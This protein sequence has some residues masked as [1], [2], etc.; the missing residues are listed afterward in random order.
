ML[1]RWQDKAA[2][3]WLKQQL[4]TNPHNPQWHYLMGQAQFNL[5]NYKESLAIFDD[6]IKT[7][8]YP[9]FQDYRDFIANTIQSV[10]QLQK[11]TTE[12]FEIFIDP[13]QDAALMPYVAETL[14][15]SY[16]RLGTLFDWFPPNR[17]RV[18]IFPTQDTF[19]PASSLSARDIEVSGAI[20]ICKFD[21][22]MLLSPRNLSRGYRWTDALSHEYIHYLLIHLSANRAPIWLHEG[23]AKYFEDA[24]RLPQS[25]WLSL[26]TET[27][28]A[29]ALENNSF[30]GF[31]NMEPSLVKLESTYQVQL[32]YA[33]AAS[34][35][36]FIVD[37]LGTTG[38]VRILRELQQTEDEG[39]TNTIARLMGYDATQFEQ[40]WRQFLTDKH[41]QAHD[42]MQLSRFTLKHTN[43]IPIHNLKQE[44]ESKTARIHVRLGDRLWQ[45]GRPRAAAGEYRRA[46]RKDPYSPYLLNKLAR[47]LMTQG[48]WQSAQH[49]LEQAKTLDPDYVVTHTNLGRLFISQ[50]A[51][52]QARQ[53]LEEAVQINPFDPNIH[54]YLANSYRRLGLADKAEQENNLFKRLQESP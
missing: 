38:L 16:Q 19:Y 3:T 31:K 49:Y 4:K 13:K 43:K 41:L 24:W 40:K 34:A 20:G 50:Q 46:L 21:K 23:I 33:E 1:K 8:P 17:I 6:L 14:E 32:A 53:A 7:F 27:L 52:E 11:I 28:L 54:Q 51:F 15:R 5:G 36:D 12:H 29:H 48:Q 47:S 18:E 37:Q 44:I 45:Q 42:G 2:R 26:R 9:H 25:A 39:A 30:V 35:I 22:I 10:S